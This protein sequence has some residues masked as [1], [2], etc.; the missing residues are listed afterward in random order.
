MNQSKRIIIGIDPGLR[1]TGYGVIWSKGSQQ[2]C[3]TFGQIKTQTKSLSGRLHQIE[4]GLRNII[5]TYQP[6]ESAI[7]Q[8]FTFYNPQSALKLGQARGAALVATSVYALPVVEYSARQIKQAVVGYGA[9]TKAQV[10]HMIRILLQL[11]KVPSADA[12]DALAIALC[13][14]ISFRLNK[15]LMRDNKFSTD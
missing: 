4:E 14:A 11:E 2:G 10:Q 3:I 8:V 7:E 12:A 15:K 6:N 9:A 5:T 13:H 1:I